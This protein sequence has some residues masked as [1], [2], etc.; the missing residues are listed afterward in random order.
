MEWQERLYIVHKT[1]ICDIL[2]WQ[3]VGS[4]RKFVV[5]FVWLLELVLLG[6]YTKLN[7]GNLSYVTKV[8]WFMLCKIYLRRGVLKISLYMNVARL[9]LGSNC[10]YWWW[11]WWLCVLCFKSSISN[12]TSSWVLYSLIVKRLFLE[13]VSLRCAQGNRWV[14]TWI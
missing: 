6:N 8:G 1:W 14:E 9:S 2:F 12:S 3:R 10:G 5:A 7:L 4:N 11:S 13:M